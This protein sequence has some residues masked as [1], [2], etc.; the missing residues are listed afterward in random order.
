MG[1]LAGAGLGER[2]T[3]QGVMAGPIMGWQEDEGQGEE[4]MVSMPRFALRAGPR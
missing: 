3:E 4:G 2:N 1:A